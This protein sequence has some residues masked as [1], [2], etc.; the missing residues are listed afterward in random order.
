MNGPS[1]LVVCFAALTAV[2]VLLG[3]LAGVIRL[4]S[5]LFPAPAPDDEA[6]L[7]AAIHTAAAFAHPDTRVTRIEEI[8]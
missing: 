1:L 8:R 7:I 6:A 2:V 4:L 5:V 3:L